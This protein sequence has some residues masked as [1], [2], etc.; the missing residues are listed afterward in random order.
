M[1]I[2][3]TVHKGASCVLIEGPRW[4]DCKFYSRWLLAAAQAERLWTEALAD[5]DFKQSV[6]LVCNSYQP[7]FEI[8]TCIML[9]RLER[10]LSTS[11]IELGSEGARFACQSLLQALA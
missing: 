7:S 10:E 5:N 2:E 4:A 1:E 9:M 8:G 6:E 11:S 3:N